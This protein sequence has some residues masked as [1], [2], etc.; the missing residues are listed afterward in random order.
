MQL[1]GYSDDYFIIRNRYVK[2]EWPQLCL[3]SKYHLRMW[4]GQPGFT[5][6][7][8]V[9]YLI[10]SW[11]PE[12]GEEGFMRLQMSKACAVDT[13][14][15]DGSGCDGGP[16]QVTVCGPCGLLYQVRAKAPHLC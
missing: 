6:L 16:A 1:V 14:P 11:G 2:R 8:S 12:W 13:T 4:E 10:R 7:P 9:F 15:S 5:S 3:S